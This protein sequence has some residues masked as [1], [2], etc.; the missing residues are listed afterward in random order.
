MEL[1]P[2]RQRRQPRIVQAEQDLNLEIEK[3]IGHERRRNG[4]IRFL[5]KWEGFSDEDATYR[6]SEDFK[7]SPYGIR[8]VKDYIQ[9]FGELPSEL[10]EW[11]RDTEWMQDTSNEDSKR[12]GASFGEGRM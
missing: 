3:I 10:E 5:C 7:T 1:F 2:N 8:V 4:N 9:T 6:A 11:M 12:S